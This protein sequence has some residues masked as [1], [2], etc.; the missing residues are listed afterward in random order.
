MCHLFWGGGA[1]SYALRNEKYFSLSK[2]CA[3][4][5]PCP[6][7]REAKTQ[8]TSRI[9][10]PGLEDLIYW[11]TSLEPALSV[12]SGL[13]QSVAERHARVPRGS[14]ECRLLCAHDAACWQNITS[15]HADAQPRSAMWPTTWS[16]A[17]A[18]SFPPSGSE[19][20]TDA[21][22]ITAAEQGQTR[23]WQASTR[24]N[25]NFTRYWQR[26]TKVEWVQKLSAHPSPTLQ[27]NKTFKALQ[28]FLYY[29]G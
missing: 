13:L 17:A 5:T 21:E 23:P 19:R 3:S 22:D 20:P 9:S 18:Q 14:S 10:N 28:T 15:T 6:C 8:K 12:S 16:T 2:R 24:W 4:Q 7:R 25:E 1:N 29:Y 27:A 26:Y 11:S